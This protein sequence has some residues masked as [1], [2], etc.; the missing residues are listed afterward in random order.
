MT[1]LRP[2]NSHTHLYTHTNTHGDFINTSTSCQNILVSSGLWRAASELNGLTQLKTSDPNRI[3]R[4]LRRISSRSFATQL[5]QMD[6][7]SIYISTKRRT[8]LQE[9]DGRR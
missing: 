4:L 9:T 1:S 7:S 5:Q 8:I 3:M 2:C 6:S